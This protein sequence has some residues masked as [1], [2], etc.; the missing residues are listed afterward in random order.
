MVRI[1]LAVADALHDL[2]EF[3]RKQGRLPEAEP[4]YRRVLSIAEKEGGP[5]HPAVGLVAGNLAEL[6]RAQGRDD[7]AEPLARRS[8]LIRRP[9][10]SARKSSSSD[11]GANTLRRS[12]WPSAMIDGDA[13]MLRAQALLVDGERTAIKRFRTPPTD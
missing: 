9:P 2:A 3:Y 13:G 10:T 8:V 4:L 7:E 6:Y 11:G 1:L 12:R 5:E